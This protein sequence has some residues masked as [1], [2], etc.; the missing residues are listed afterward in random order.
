MA[1]A[2]ANPDHIQR[3]LQ[4]TKELLQAVMASTDD[5]RLK[6]C[7]SNLDKVKALMDGD[8]ETVWRIEAEQRQRD[9]E[10]HRRMERNLTKIHNERLASVRLC[11]GRRSWL[12]S[13]PPPTAET[14][15]LLAALLAMQK[16]SPAP[17]PAPQPESQ[18]QPSPEDEDLYT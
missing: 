12:P 7:F 18:P 6:N 9:T 8:Y 14:S 5:Y 1:A 15:P 3:C 17:A 4:E 16:V 10:F 13:P 11:S 2:T